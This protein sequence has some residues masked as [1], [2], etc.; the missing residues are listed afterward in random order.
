MKAY[1]ATGRDLAV[2]ARLHY[3]VMLGVREYGYE[4]AGANSDRRDRE[5]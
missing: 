5:G 1:L 3:N 2:G 4:R